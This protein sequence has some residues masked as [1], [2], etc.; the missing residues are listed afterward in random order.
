MYLKAESLAKINSTFLEQSS[1]ELKDFLKP[2]VYTVLQ[3]ELEAARGEGAVVGPAN[4]RQY[5]R[6]LRVEGEQESLAPAP[7]HP[8]LQRILKA[9]RSQA[10]AKF[11]TSVTGIAP[12]KYY[13]EVRSLDR[14]HYTLV[15]DHSLEPVG[16]DV[17]LSCLSKTATWDPAWGGQIVYM[18]QDDEL[19]SVFPASNSLLIVFRDEG[20]MRFVK[21]VNHYAEFPIPQ[22]SFV[23]LE[24]EEE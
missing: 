16:V 7:A 19:L 1:I 15:H 12:A 14:T 8:T 23:Y 4:R 9:L 3:Q 22:I 2:E 11:L 10:F 6:L 24:Q 20:T 13:G 5:R 21:Y 17:V 18:D